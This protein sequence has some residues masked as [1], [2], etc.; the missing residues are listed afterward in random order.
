[1]LGAVESSARRDATVNSHTCQGT[2][3]I[4]ERSLLD[5]EADQLHEL[6]T[7]PSAESVGPAKM[8]LL[9]TGLINMHVGP[10]RFSRSSGLN[11]Y[12]IT[13]YSKARVHP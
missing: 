1:M 10:L 4:E 12:I 9:L 2:N 8:R 3:H 7:H 6:A 11:E 5:R 13:V